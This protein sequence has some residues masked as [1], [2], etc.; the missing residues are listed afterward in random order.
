MDP[1]GQGLGDLTAAEDLD[2]ALV[3]E[4][5]GAQPFAEQARPGTFAGTSLRVSPACT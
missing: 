1:D 4:A 3:H 2:E 5:L